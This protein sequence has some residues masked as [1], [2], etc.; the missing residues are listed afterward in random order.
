MGAEVLRAIHRDF[1]WDDLYGR[2][3]EAVRDAVLAR[4]RAARRY[5]A[6]A[7]SFS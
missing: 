6:E 1:V 7:Y 4:V 5:K 3:Y 2:A